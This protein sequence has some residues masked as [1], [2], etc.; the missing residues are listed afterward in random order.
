[1]RVYFLHLQIHGP[2]EK[3][4]VYCKL[5]LVRVCLQYKSKVKLP[6]L[7]VADCGYFV[8]VVTV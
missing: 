2:C 3:H 4:I 1:M 7:F 6:F 8:H 5:L